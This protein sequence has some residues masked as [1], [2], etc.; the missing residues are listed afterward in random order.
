[1]IVLYFLINLRVWS[2][3]QNIV[4]NDSNCYYKRH[5]CVR[6][7]SH[8]I[9]HWKVHTIVTR[10]CLRNILWYIHVACEKSEYI[11]LQCIIPNTRNVTGLFPLWD[12]SQSRWGYART[13][14]TS[15]EVTSANQNT[16][17]YSKV[18]YK[19]TI[20][21]I[22]PFLLTGLSSVMSSV[23][24][25]VLSSVMSSILQ[26]SSSSSYPFRVEL[27]M[28][29]F[30][31]R[32]LY[33]QLLDRGYSHFPDD[34]LLWPLPILLYPILATYIIRDNNI[35]QPNI[36]NTT[37]YVKMVCL[38]LF[39]SSEIDRCYDSKNNR[40]SMYGLWVP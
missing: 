30:R 34:L 27:N 24:S 6:C 29:M 8:H 13:C 38:Q 10:W 18:Q 7:H 31:L 1:M 28:L 39:Y 15:R 17:V 35:A 21:Q 37:S 23:L 9:F 5:K 22:I 32:G 26:L 2:E 16:V 19:A 3:I 40:W 11:S 20:N 36:T 4:I 14:Y 12:I 33:R 25:S